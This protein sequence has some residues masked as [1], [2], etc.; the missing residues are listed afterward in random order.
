[1]VDT[2][3]DI[4]KDLRYAMAGQKDPPEPGEVEK[5][6][7]MEK[8]GTISAE[9]QGEFFALMEKTKKEH[10]AAAKALWNAMNPFVG[11]KP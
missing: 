9:L 1:M 8:P 5:P 3:S 2:I 10:P 6:D 7:P 11:A 4:K